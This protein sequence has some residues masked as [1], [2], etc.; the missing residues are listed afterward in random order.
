VRWALP[1]PCSH[2]ENKKS[3]NA[4]MKAENWIERLTMLSYRVSEY[5]ML[6]L[7]DDAAMLAFIF[8]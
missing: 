2:I 3:D 5:A 7:A 4:G 8:C 1:S 6:N